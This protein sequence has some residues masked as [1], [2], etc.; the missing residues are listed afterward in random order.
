[1]RTLIAQLVI[2]GMLVFMVSSSSFAAGSNVHLESAPI[3][4]HDKESLR[5]GARYFMNYCHSCHALGLSRYSRMAADM[6][7]PVDADQ[8]MAEGMEADQA[9]AVAD[10]NSKAVTQNLIFT[11]DEKGQPVKIGSLMTNAMPE[12]DAAA[13]FGAAPP[14]LSLTGRLRGGDWIYSYLKGFY[15]DPNKPTG[16]NNTV[17]PDVAMPHILWELQGFQELSKDGA[18]KLAEKGSMTPLEYDRVVGDITNFLV[19]VSEPIQLHRYRYGMIAMVI[20]LI[21]TVLAYLL[22][23]EYWK[24]VH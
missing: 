18:L 12:K 13:W 23:K 16:V 15:L 4:L 1:M 24:D 9:A 20:L 17:F 11:K 19:Y 14:D 10:A 21:F 7:I 2:S 5:N 8:A 6:G 22:K 3:D